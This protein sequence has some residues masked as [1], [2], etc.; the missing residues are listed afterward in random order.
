MCSERGGIVALLV[1]ISMLGPGNGG[2]VWGEVKI[3]RMTNFDRIIR[4]FC[5]W[6][7]FHNKVK[8]KTG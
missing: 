7:D 4:D 2:F 6:G 8:F 1:Y 5:F 3:L